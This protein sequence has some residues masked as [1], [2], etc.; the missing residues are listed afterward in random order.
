MRRSI[1]EHIK[2]TLEIIKFSC[3]KWETYNGSLLQC[4]AKKGKEIKAG[5]PDVHSKIKI[6]TVL[7]LVGGS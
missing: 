5:R 3:H 4:M 6:L 7:R 1:V 2:F